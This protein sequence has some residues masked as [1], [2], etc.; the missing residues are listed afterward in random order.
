MAIPGNSWFFSAVKP[1]LH[2]ANFEPPSDIV[3]IKS[4]TAKP[5]GGSKSLI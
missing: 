5:F 3:V 4:T 1:F 2:G